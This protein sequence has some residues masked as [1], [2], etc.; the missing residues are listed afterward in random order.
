MTPSARRNSIGVYLRLM[1]GPGTSPH[2]SRLSFWALL[3]LLFGVC[4]WVCFHEPMAGDCWTGS[5]WK[6]ILTS[7]PAVARLI[8]WNYLTCNPRFGETFLYLTGGSRA[9]H[10][11]LTPSVI[12]LTVVGLMTLAL[13]RWPRPR[14][15]RD[16]G[17]LIL[18]VALV[19]VS[20]STLGQQVFYRPHATNYLYG[21]GVQV[22]FLVPLRIY[23]TKVSGSSVVNARG[24]AGPRWWSS[25][26]MLVLGFVAGM[27]NEH[28]GPALILAVLLLGVFTLRRRP[29]VWPWLL[30][31]FVGVVAGY[32]A[33]FF[34][35]GQLV[36][37]AGMGRQ[38]I[39]ERIAAQGPR[40]VLR[41]FIS[42]VLEARL[43]LLILI[44][45]VAHGA[46]RRW[47]GRPTA[48]P[49]TTIAMLLGGAVAIVASLLA[50]PFTAARLLLASALLVAVAALAALLPALDTR[51]T[52]V[53]AVGIASVIVG[54]HAVRFV[55]VFSHLDED[56]RARARFLEQAPRGQVAFVKP[57]R[58]FFK[59]HW[60]LGDDLVEEGWRRSIGGRYGMQTLALDT[61]DPRILQ[62]SGVATGW[63]VEGDPTGMVD[64][65]PPE[66][67]TPVLK[68]ESRDS[69]ERARQYL[70]ETGPA[71]LEA[72]G[73]AARGPCLRLY[74]PPALSSD[75]SLC[76]GRW[77]DGALL[78]A[79]QTERRGSA[80][81]FHFTAG[82]WRL[83][84]TYIASLDG[85]I[86]AISGTEQ[87]G[88][89]VYSFAPSRRGVHLLIGCDDR[90]CVVGGVAQD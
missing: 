48:T 56:Y 17:I 78:P 68:F 3:A 27:C 9:L 31:A 40:G 37:Y 58:H 51:R 84:Q 72:S 28:T 4:A 43:G 23:V 67:P 82:S 16:S 66:M 62:A 14:R 54:F 11:V 80:Q 86:E 10:A 44:A 41:L 60:A 79:A 64:L 57:V 83:P 19:C 30:A 85:K 25:A 55:Q 38:P 26:G 5:D 63:Q 32:L 88:Q 89:L 24:E 42:F 33:L 15:S 29:A 45:T 90:V 70:I 21:F 34:A 81:T 75:K 53:A 61:Q 22:W 69:F 74:L 7:I 39:L 71:V 2:V 59:S 36:R 49:W 50:S 52:F 13:G 77:I 1:H 46:Y 87:A 76:I 35:P 12:V 18:M 73:G 65:A 47:R 6:S 8:E 20:V